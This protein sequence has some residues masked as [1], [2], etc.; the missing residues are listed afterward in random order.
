MVSLV[1]LI[2]V[3]SAIFACA[4][5]IYFMARIIVCLVEHNKQQF[6]VR[7]NHIKRNHAMCFETARDYGVKN[8]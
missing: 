6:I 4:A 2:A 3:I 7:T 1:I 8:G 5:L